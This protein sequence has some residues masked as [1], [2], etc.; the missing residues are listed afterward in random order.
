MLSFFEKNEKM[1]NTFMIGITG[2]I[3][4]GRRNRKV[5]N[6]SVK[7]KRGKMKSEQGRTGKI[8]K[9]GRLSDLKK[10]ERR[11]I[12]TGSVRSISVLKCIHFVLSVHSLHRVCMVLSAE[13]KVYGAT[14]AE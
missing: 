5:W 7:N 2:H 13:C 11:K 8:G 4:K 12:R 6:K 1:Q 10:G 3:G 14:N 9:K